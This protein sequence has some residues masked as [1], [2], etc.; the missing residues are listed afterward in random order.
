MTDVPDW[1]KKYW[2]NRLQQKTSGQNQQMPQQPHYEPL[3]VTQ[4]RTRGQ[5]PNQLIRSLG[6]Q[7]DGF[8]N[9]DDPR[10]AASR[11]LTGQLSARDQVPGGKVV[12]LREGARYFRQVQS[13]AYGVSIPLLRS[14]GQITNVTGREFELRGPSRGYVIDGLNVIDAGKMNESPERFVSLIKV[15]APF[16]GDIFVESSAVIE[17]FNGQRSIL[18]G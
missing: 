17:S 4:A 2:A 1:E 18:R 14:M 8:S 15:R 5:D 10:V 6:V 3:H 11:E 13:E 7:I 9:M 12:M 16:V